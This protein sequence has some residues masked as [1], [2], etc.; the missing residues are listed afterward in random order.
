MKNFINNQKR[1]RRFCL[2]LSIVT[3]SLLTLGGIL[4]AGVLDRLETQYS[5]RQFLPKNHELITRE[6]RIK[7]QFQLGA[8]PAILVMLD[9]GKKEGGDWLEPKRIAKLRAATE[10]FAT[11]PGIDAGLSIATVEGAMNSRAGVNV[12]KLLEGTQPRLWHKRVLNDPLLTPQLI[13]QDARTVLIVL[14]RGELS[15]QAILGLTKTI[16][17]DLAKRF[18][19][20]RVRIGGVPTMQAEMSQLLTDELGKLSLYALIAMALTLFMIFSNVGSVLVTL[21]ITALANIAV[22]AWMALTGTTFTILSTTLPIL[23]SVNAVS[24]VAYTMIRFAELRA[25]QP[26]EPLGKLRAI[27]Q[28]FAETFVPNL[29]ASA[30]TCVGFGALML[31]RVP[32]IVQYG[33]VVALSVAIAW[34]CAMI[35]LPPCLLLLPTPKPRKWTQASARWSLR[36]T[37]HPKF[38]FAAILAAAAV[39]GFVGRH[40]NWSAT[41]FTEMPANH[42]ARRTTERVDRA[43]G[44]MIPLDIVVRYRKNDT[45]NDPNLVRKLDQVTKS[46]RTRAEIGSA[47]ALPDFLRAANLAKDGKLPERRAAIAETLFLYSMSEGRPVDQF[48]TSDGRATRIALRLHDVPGDHMAATVASVVRETKKVFPGARV[49]PT[50][51][52]TTV[53][54]LNNELS[55][56]LIY[57]FWQALAFIGILLVFIYRSFFWTIAAVIPN[58]LPPVV[59]LGFMSLLKEPIKPGLAII[60]SIA[61]GLAFNNTVYFLG[62]LR[63]LY[64]E[65]PRKIPPVKRALY[66]E[67]VP[68]LLSTL[69]LLTGFLVFLA[70]NFQLNQTFGVYMLIAIGA[71]V[72]SDLVFLP[73]MVQLFPGIVRPLKRKPGAVRGPGAEVIE[74]PV[75]AR[76]S[77]REKESE[78]PSAASFALLF[79]LSLAPAWAEAGAGN[80]KEILERVNKNMSATDESATVHMRIIEKNG[81]KKDREMTIQRSS[82]GSAKNVL[83]RLHS[84]SDIRGTSLL[85]VEK[86]TKKDQWL[87]LPS[88]KKSRRILS[89]NQGGNFLGSELSYEDMGGSQGVQ[90]DSKV[91]RTE[92]KGATKVAV[93]ESTPKAGESAYSKIV[94]WVPLDKYVVTKVDYYDKRGKLL[95]TALFANYKQFSGTWRATK[96]QIKNVQN[97]R[98]TVMAL[99]GLAI[100]KGIDE[101]TFSVANLEEIE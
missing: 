71:G 1:F 48:V 84:P 44:G 14:E 53:H 68:C 93:I 98:G 88:T 39:L 85:S 49:V 59:L 73:T 41:L 55:I 58:F 46:F 35:A 3:L 81:A 20:S 27:Y 77:A 62:R 28:V 2:I 22:L 63:L 94:S 66:L 11:L 23:I 30:T 91:I 24:M 64:Q 33:G 17:S 83:V 67:G 43:M 31:S 10:K 38:A 8:M 5:M 95:K 9:L 29:L 18:P 16:R 57:G 70:S 100:N 36:I 13:S 74:L 69:P 76:E 37:A 52:A 45:W 54:H 78:M 4:G 32:M 47:V 21:Y 87:F 65:G 40:Q 96:M 6:D 26:A 101:D 56:E 19:H 7:A 61:L 99:K 75:V 89:Q 60:F 34:T 82:K 86:G 80:A 79:A 42:E 15:N 97:G 12:G 92:T 51:M 25:L 72:L 90:F 50:N